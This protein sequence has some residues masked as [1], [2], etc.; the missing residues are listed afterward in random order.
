MTSVT[1]VIPS[2]NQGEYL[3]AALQSV[4]NQHVHTETIVI[5]GGST[6][7][8]LDVIKKNESRIFWWRSRKDA[9]QAAAINEGV[10]KGTAPYVCWLNSDDFFLP[11]GLVKLFNTLESSLF[12]PAAYGKC[13]IVDKNGIKKKAY[14]TARFT[15]KHLANRCFI[16]QPATLIRRSAWEQIGGLNENLHMSMDYDL[17]WRLYKHCGKLYHTKE[18]VAASRWHS[19]SKTYLFRRAHYRES[20]MVVRNHY[21]TVPLKWYAA[22]PIRVVLWHYLN[23]A[24]ELL[25]INK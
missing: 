19:A 8:S 7:N 10:K 1:V 14:W 6:D 13:L 24:S 17:W 21:G 3:E 5:D 22:W 16:A 2:Y 25:G 12:A 9:G 4:F 18:A 23:K 15:E 20:M 11:D